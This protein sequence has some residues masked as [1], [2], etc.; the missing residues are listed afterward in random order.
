VYYEVATRLAVSTSGS[1]EKFYSQAMDMTGANA[2]YVCTATFAISGG[3]LN[4]TLQEGNDLDN[5]FD[6]SVAGGTIAIN[7]QGIGAMKVGS[8]AARYV[9]LKY[10]MFTASNRAVLSA[11]V[12]TA[13]L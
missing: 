4:V 6:I 5:W 1:S 9:R 3:S 13:Q 10:T 2:V 8:I 12:N 7:Q 11:N